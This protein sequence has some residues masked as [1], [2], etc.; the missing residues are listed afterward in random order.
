MGGNFYAL[1]AADGRKL[2]GE[3]IGGAIS[4][5]IIALHERY[6]IVEF[7]MGSC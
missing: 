3:K 2:W 5:G 1:D 7:A 6:G 4:G